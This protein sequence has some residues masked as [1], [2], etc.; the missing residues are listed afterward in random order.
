MVTTK[1]MD[2]YPEKIWLQF[3]ILR[4]IYENPTYGYQLIKNINKISHGKYIVKSGTMY[5]TLRRMEKNKLL[6]SIWE[7]NKSGPSSRIYNITVEGKMKLKSL[8]KMVVERK[9]I[10]DQMIKFYEKEF[11]E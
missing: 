11:K 2:N 9:K 5:T 3:L 1:N 6:C 7:K 8:L 10:I 4:L